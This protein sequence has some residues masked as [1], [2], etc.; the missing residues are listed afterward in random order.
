LNKT[1]YHRAL[2]SARAE[3]D[4]LTQERNELELR[5][6]HLKQTIVGL[7]ALCNQNLDASRSPDDTLPFPRFMKLTG[8]TRQ[9]LAES[10][11]P[12][13]PSQVRDA[14]AHRG[15]NVS[16]YTNQMAVIH[17]TLLRLKRQGEAIQVSGAWILTEKG[18]LASKM[19][20]M[21]SSL[22]LNAEAAP[23]DRELQKNPRTRKIHKM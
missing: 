18:K 4:R 19:D 1:D 5:I 14:L 22:P 21:D 11:L 6:V 8:A 13:N 2:Q 9:V 10:N 15:L 12:I 23:E 16:H 20:L 7:M 3:F 17:N